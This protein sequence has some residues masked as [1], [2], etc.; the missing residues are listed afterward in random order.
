MEI[1]P[2]PTKGDFELRQIFLIRKYVNHIG[3]PKDKKGKIDPM[4]VRRPLLQKDLKGLPCKHDWN[5]H[6][7]AGIL[8]Y[9]QWLTRP[10]IAMSV[11]Q[12][13]RFNNDLIILHE[14]AIQKA[15]KYLMETEYRG[16]IYKPDNTKG[17][18]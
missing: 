14:W 17:I 12:Y 18:Q 10:D 6:A 11:H 15:V 2:W 4:L 13:A 16:I 8:S 7:A 1:K 5:Y 9:L 3:L